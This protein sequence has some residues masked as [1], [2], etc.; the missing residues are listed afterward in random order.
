[1]SLN[2]QLLFDSYTPFNIIDF[3][4]VDEKNAHPISV[5][6][7]VEEDIHGGI[8]SLAISLAVRDF[9]LFSAVGIATSIFMHMVVLPYLFPKDYP[10]QKLKEEEV[11]EIY[12]DA[13]TNPDEEEFDDTIPGGLVIL[14]IVLAVHRSFGPYIKSG[15][16]HRHLRS[17]TL[18]EALLNKISHTGLNIW[19]NMM[20]TRKDNRLCN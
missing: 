11:D 18:R 13:L 14:A 8:V 16:R 19:P 12:E 10:R 15:V 5:G 3:A 17:V 9:F 6:E 4:R 2:Q 20:M 7:G 1:M